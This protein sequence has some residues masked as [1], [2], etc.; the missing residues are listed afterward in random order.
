MPGDLAP[1]ARGGGKHG[2]HDKE[3]KERNG[4]VGARVL[5]RLG[6]N[7]GA[8]EEDGD[9]AEGGKGLVKLGGNAGVGFEGRVLPHELHGVPYDRDGDPEGDDADGDAEIDEEGL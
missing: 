5:T 9:G 8:D 7:H 6:G 4:A 2:D 1:V 3:A